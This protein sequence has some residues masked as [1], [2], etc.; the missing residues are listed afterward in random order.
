MYRRH[1]VIILYFIYVLPIVFS[2][3]RVRITYSK[4]YTRIHTLIDISRY[5]VTLYIYVCV[6]YIILYFR[7]LPTYVYLLKVLILYGFRTAPAYVVHAYFFP[8]SLWRFHIL[9]FFLTTPR[10]RF[11]CNVFV[12]I[13]MFHTYAMWT[14]CLEMIRKNTMLDF[15]SVR[16]FSFFFFF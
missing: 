2:P 16:C 8:C 3:G 15:C 10:V 6:I 9:L 14:G 12:C 4:V 11:T 1:N 7:L 5:R 13:Y